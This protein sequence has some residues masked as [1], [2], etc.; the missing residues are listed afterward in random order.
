M[1]SVSSPRRLLPQAAVCSAGI[2][3]G[4][5]SHHLFTRSDSALV[6]RSDAP[7]PVPTTVIQRF[8]SSPPHPLAPAA[9]SARPPVD[10]AELGF[11][12]RKILRSD[13]QGT[14]QFKQLVIWAENATEDE[15]K[16]ALKL[17]PPLLKDE[18]QRDL[19]DCAALGRLAEIDGEMAVEVML[20]TQ[21]DRTDPVSYDAQRA[22]FEGWA[23][24]DPQGALKGV[25]VR[26]Q[27]SEDKSSAMLVGSVITEVSHEF[28]HLAR[29]VATGLARSDD[30]NLRE[31]GFQAHAN[32]LSQQLDDGATLATALAWVTATQ[33]SPEERQH[34]LGSLVQRS[35]SKEGPGEALA[36]FRQ[37]D[38][39]KNPEVAGRLILSLAGSDPASA[40]E[41]QLTL[42]EG[43]NRQIITDNL[44]ATLAEQ[45]GPASVFDWLAA[46]PAHPDFDQAFEHLANI[47]GEEEGKG[48]W[49]CA[50]RIS[51][52][53][54]R[55]NELSYNIAFKW[56]KADF[57]AAAR[58]LPPEY[59]DRYQRSTALLQELTVMLPGLSPNLTLG[60]NRD[61]VRFD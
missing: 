30:E 22:L 35:L 25:L 52:D 48:A 20:A 41:L 40:K 8:P 14:R 55:K 19:I 46:Q 42:P 18:G 16:L 43:K 26:C 32:L 38:A 12:L 13:G 17:G 28:P 27:E 33:V 57:S 60:L 23:S 11:R 58:E 47:F 1:V 6:A 37:M 9:S 10:E 15:L 31:I 50:M 45:K 2:L 51:G 29:D 54:E 49:A 21:R 61:G 56:L 53:P 59:V 3:L 44:V 34:L 5:L 7:P 39:T 4:V 36:I 24:W